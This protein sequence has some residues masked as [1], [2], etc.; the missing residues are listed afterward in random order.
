[1]TNG[2]AC[3]TV[4][5]ITLNADKEKLANLSGT[6]KTDPCTILEKGNRHI[7]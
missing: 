7:V 4:K 3:A 1:M 6:A 5:I 2:T